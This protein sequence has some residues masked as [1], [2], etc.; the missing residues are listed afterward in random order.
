[1]IILSRYFIAVESTDLTRIREL[2]DRIARVSSAE[3]W[4]EELNPA[5]RS[6]LSYLAR[7][8]RFSRAPSNVADYLCTTRGTASQTLKALERKGFVRQARSPADKRSI[9]C[10]VTKKGRAALGAPS[11][12][13]A[14][15]S[16]L[17]A[18][19]AE[20]LAQ[21]LEATV[22]RVLERQGFRT[23]GVCRTCR[24]HRRTGDALACALLDLPLT[25]AAANE[26]CHEHD[27]PPASGR[28]ATE[29]G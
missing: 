19:E 3:E 1:M 5:Q 10:D 12:F 16:A 22:R 18:P 23:F 9:S 25:E 15:L 27:P 2:F 11:N 17:L 20:A 4:S 24:H 8:N 26:L 21:T 6:A 14:A 7:A 28:G 13:G 29:P